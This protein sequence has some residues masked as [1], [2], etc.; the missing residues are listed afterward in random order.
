L[1]PKRTMKD[2]RVYDTD[3]LTRLGEVMALRALGLKLADIAKLLKGRTGD[4]GRMLELQQEDLLARRGQIEGA[5]SL[6]GDL[7][8][9]AAM[10]ETLTLNDLT[11]AIKESHMTT[12]SNDTVSWKRY[13]QMRPRV[14]VS[15]DPENFSGCVGYYQLGPD[16][17]FDVFDDNG[18]PMA[19]LTGQ[20]A[21]QIFPE[22]KDRYFYTAVPAQLVFERDENG[23]VSALVL[24]QNGEEKRAPRVSAALAQDIQGGLAER[25]RSG[26]PVA[27]AADVLEAM[28]LGQMSGK[29]RYDL[30]SDALAKLAEE[31]NDAFSKELI[32]HGALKSFSFLAVT[33]EGW[34]VFRAVFE[35]GEM[36]CSVHMSAD[37][38]ADGAMF[39]APRTEAFWKKVVQKFQT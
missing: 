31:Q 39:D 20:T 22:A 25:I 28:L 14:A 36:D 18:A 7:R 34:D 15:I 12:A 4:I 38:K 2:W 24:H 13:E 17:V 30:M 26:T 32:E 35:N 1:T 5:L 9:R 29:P 10:G 21:L 11:T 19:S 33:P 3:D 27:N 8:Q 23:V 16:A 37:G 6:V